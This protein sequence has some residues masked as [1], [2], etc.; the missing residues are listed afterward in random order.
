MWTINAYDINGK[1]TVL[2]ILGEPMMFWHKEDAISFLKE[3]GYT[4]DEI[5]DL[6]IEYE[7]Q[8]VKNGIFK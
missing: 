5:D 8:Y 3:K 6:S 7:E 2:D 4:N 1:H